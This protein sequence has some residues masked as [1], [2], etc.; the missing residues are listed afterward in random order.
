MYPLGAF[1]REE[2]PSKERRDKGEQ[3]VHNLDGIAGDVRTTAVKGDKS[4]LAG[5]SPGPGTGLLG[6]KTETIDFFSV[7]TVGCEG[8]RAVRHGTQVTQG[9]ELYST[10]HAIHAPHVDAPHVDAPLL[11]PA[12]PSTVAEYLTSRGVGPASA[13]YDWHSELS[14]GIG[15]LSLDG[16]LRAA[17]A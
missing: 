10:G 2:L 4:E 5:P 11:S 1:Y 6:R 15:A 7:D 14:T 8:V 9:T 3:E 12:V 13:A 16:S 17:A